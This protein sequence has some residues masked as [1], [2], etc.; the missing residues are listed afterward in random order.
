MGGR[1]L[2]EGTIPSARS[3][4]LREG[5]SGPEGDTRRGHPAGAIIS[6]PAHH[7]VWVWG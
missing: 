5:A 6:R 1:R 2:F 4:A 3:K 7:H